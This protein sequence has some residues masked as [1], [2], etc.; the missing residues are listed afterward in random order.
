MHL[1][2]DTLLLGN[3]DDARQPMAAIGALLVVAEEYQVEPRDGRRTRL[4]GRAR[5]MRYVRD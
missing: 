4:Y 3:I 5:L 2:T 1:I